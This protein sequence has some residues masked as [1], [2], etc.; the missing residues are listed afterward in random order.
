MFPL[1]M[2]GI[3]KAMRELRRREVRPE[4]ES[5]PEPKPTPEPVR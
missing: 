5:A 4:L 2:G 1:T 3:T